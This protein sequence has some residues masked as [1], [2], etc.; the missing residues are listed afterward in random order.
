M[1]SRAKRLTFVLAVAAVVGGSIALPT[2]AAEKVPFYAHG[3][4]T[5]VDEQ[6]PIATVVGEGEAMDLGPFT[7]LWIVRDKK[8]GKSKSTG[9]LT[10]EDGATLEM[11]QESEWDLSDPDVIRR[12][13]TFKIVGGTGPFAGAKGGGTVLL[14]Y[15]GEKKGRPV[16]EGWHEGTISY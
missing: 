9:T 13:G 12:T 4:S 1:A 11:T 6:G 5:I 7:S 14:I 15:L 8:W 2:Q 3:I 16:F 10:F